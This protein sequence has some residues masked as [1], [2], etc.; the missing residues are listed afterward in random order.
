MSDV[1]KL[2]YEL[3]TKNKIN[4][5]FDIELQTAGKDWLYGF[6][7]R[8]KELSLRNP[9]KTSI[10]RAMGFNKQVVG[11]FFDLLEGLYN[12]YNFAPNDIYNVDE[13]GITT[14]PNKPSK[15]LALKGKKQVGSLTSAERGV[16]ITAEICMSA[17]GN[18]M[19]TMFV[20][21]RKRENPI[22][23]DDAPP[24]SFAQYH[25]SG[26]MQS[27]IFI[28][29]FKKFIE[30]SKPSAE[31]PV[32]LILD[33]HATHTK[34]IELINIARANH[35]ILLCLPPHCSHRMQ[36]LDV[37]FM[38]PL[39]T[40]YQQEVR[41]WLAMHPG[42][43]VTIHQVAKLYGKAYTR[44]AVMQT[45]INGFRS[46]GIYPLNRYIFPEHLFVPSETTDRHAAKT[47]PT[48]ECSIS[49]DSASLTPTG[50][51]LQDLLTQP[52]CSKETPSFSVA[53]PSIE[54]T[55]DN[56]KI[57]SSCSNFVPATDAA[58]EPSTSAKISSFSVSPAAL[59]P[60][61]HHERKVSKNNRRKGKTA[62][63]TS[64]PY[65]CEL[66]AL[67][68]EKKNGKLKKDKQQKKGKRLFTDTASREK[69]QKAKA[70]K[71]KKVR[72]RT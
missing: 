37:T 66:E 59:M 41:Q 15:V 61:P 25:P 64:S 22:L 49:T 45:A 9:E 38:G 67:A 27:E 26:W 29:W 28:F 13:T 23:M 18:F 69:V 48:A 6:L 4:H 54:P 72:H 11:H 12:K 70:V 60:P 17:S 68:D 33:G 20:F 7:S 2:A 42:R 51:S 35:V 21:P 24:G 16:L 34:S 62:I 65:K 36:P 53:M 44:A 43:A 19:P 3:A 30:F 32:L 50:A 39:S 8:H 1:R 52:S 57:L 56:I 58:P 63:L 46:T 71:Q 40:Y 47:Q 14:V 10:S 55:Q 31:K 5:C